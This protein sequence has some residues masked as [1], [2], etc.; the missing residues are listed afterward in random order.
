ML[1]YREN[2]KLTKHHIFQTVQAKCIN[3]RSR[4]EL[5]VLHKAVGRKFK[6]NG[7]Q[8]GGAAILKFTKT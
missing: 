7:I 6:N 2:E 5:V 1:K 3:F 8:D 4:I